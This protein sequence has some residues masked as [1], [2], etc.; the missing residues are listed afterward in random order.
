ME[1][2]EQPCFKCQH[3]PIHV[4]ECLNAECSEQCECRGTKWIYWCP[5]CGENPLDDYEAEVK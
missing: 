4:E 5:K 2:I 1:K 3:T